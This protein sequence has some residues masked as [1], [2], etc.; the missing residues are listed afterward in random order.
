MNR[1]GIRCKTYSHCVLRSMIIWSFL[2]LL[3]VI[4]RF[5][6]WRSRSF[7]I[8]HGRDILLCINTWIVSI[9]HIKTRAL[10]MICIVLAYSTQWGNGPSWSGWRVHMWSYPM[11]SDYQMRWIGDRSA[12]QQT[13]R[14]D[15]HNKIPSPWGASSLQDHLM[16]YSIERHAMVSIK[17]LQEQ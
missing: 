10:G 14:P 6:K 2:R 3:A 8:S 1:W 16:K 11:P 15:Y 4:M 17:I 5:L 9:L 7:N 13:A 12:F